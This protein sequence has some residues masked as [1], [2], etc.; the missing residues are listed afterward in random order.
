MLP[1]QVS[2]EFI[3]WK[4]HQHSCAFPSGFVSSFVMRMLSCGFVWSWL[5]KFFSLHYYCLLHS[6][7]NKKDF[8]KQYFFSIESLYCVD[9]KYK[10]DGNVDISICV[11]LDLLQNKRLQLWKQQSP[12]FA[13]ICRHHIECCIVHRRM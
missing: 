4:R 8:V 10:I 12:C 5:T 7:F 13:G 9:R 2:F 11:G 1:V 3:N 6:R